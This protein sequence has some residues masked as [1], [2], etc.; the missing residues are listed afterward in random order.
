MTLVPGE[1]EG[2][3]AD[4]VEHAV[5]EQFVSTFGADGKLTTTPVSHGGG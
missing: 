5:P 2:E 3:D 4:A 1:E